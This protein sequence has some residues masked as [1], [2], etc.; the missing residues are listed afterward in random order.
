MGAHSSP[1][2]Q[3][4]ENNSTKTLRLAFTNSHSHSSQQ[5]GINTDLQKSNPSSINLSSK[6]QTPST[7]T[8][9]NPKH[10]SILPTQSTHNSILTSHHHNIPLHPLLQNH[11]QLPK[12]R[13]FPH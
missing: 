6:L 1:I 2:L 11:H 9:P 7:L 10:P 4:S 8:R 3:G 13:I 12:D 5:P